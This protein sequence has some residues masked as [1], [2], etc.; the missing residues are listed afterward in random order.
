MVIIFLDVDGVLNNINTPI[1]LKHYPFE[2]LC[3]RNLKNLVEQVDAKIVISSSIRHCFDNMQALFFQ[4]KEYDLD[5][6]VIGNTPFIDGDKSKEI[7]SYLNSIDDLD[8][9]IVLDD[10]ALSVPYLIRTDKQIVLKEETV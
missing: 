1:G 4:L 10:E 6:R 8:A 5:G 9:F 7:K 3:F 2:P